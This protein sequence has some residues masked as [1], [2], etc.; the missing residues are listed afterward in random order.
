MAFEINPL[1]QLLADG[2]GLT[3]LMK[4]K[5]RQ[6]AISLKVVVCTTLSHNVPDHSSMLPCSGKGHSDSLSFLCFTLTCYLPKKK[7][8]KA[9]TVM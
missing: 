7:K 5:T 2:S 6:C 3:R 4:Q 8:S 1:N 9:L